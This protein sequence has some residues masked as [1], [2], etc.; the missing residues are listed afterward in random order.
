M[1]KQGILLVNL[2]SPDSPDVPQVRQYLKEFLMD[3]RVIDLPLPLRWF[4]VN[5]MIIPRRAEQ[6]AHAYRSI[7]SPHGSPLVATG[8]TVAHR[9]EAVLD[10]P[11]A[12]SMRYRAPSVSLG[13]RRLHK[14]GVRDL[15]IVPLFPH[16]AMSSYETAM[17]H[18][19]EKI[20]ALMPGISRRYLPPIF[21]EPEYL[22]ALAATATGT[23]TDDFDH[24]LF[25]FHGLPLRHLRKA[26]PTGVHCMGSANCCSVDSPARPTCYRAQCYATARGV[27]ERLRLPAGKWSVAFQSRLGRDPWMRP[28]T[29]ETLGSLG[30]RGMQRLFVICPAFVADCLETLEEIAIRGRETFRAAGGGELTLIPCLNTHPAWI[31][32]LSSMISR[33]FAAPAASTPEFSAAER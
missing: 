4:L 21:E 9:L 30:K 28:Y 13:L 3:G 10:M 1:S 27:A 16:Y 7:W 22:D 12:I 25:S 20:K 26:D 24:L 2:G 6:S 29:E 15:L 18:V 23:L 14:A 31:D 19:E 8:R 5:C 33:N 11:V 32:A 17:L